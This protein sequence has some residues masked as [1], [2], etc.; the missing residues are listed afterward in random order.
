MHIDSA[1]I[2]PSTITDHYTAG[3]ASA[4]Q[5]PW[6]IHGTWGNASSS[7]TGA[8]GAVIAGTCIAQYPPVCTNVGEI[9]FAGLNAAASIV[10]TWRVG[11]EVIAPPLSPYATFMSAPIPHDPI[12]IAAYHAIAR[13]MLAAYPSEYN[14]FGALF[15]VIKGVGSKVLPAL[16]NL[17]AGSK[18][19]QA[20]PSYAANPIYP[21]PSYPP[22]STN[23][24][25]RT[26]PKP[27]IVYVDRPVMSASYER[28]KG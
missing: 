21:P 24:P 14:I 8:T 4:K 7:G 3:A 19:P 27:Q 12:A 18:D 25:M 9:L 22:P 1:S 2:D 10:L 28:N 20:A 6:G 26:P 23:Y 17:F 5:P 15:N 16:G 13:E 11:F